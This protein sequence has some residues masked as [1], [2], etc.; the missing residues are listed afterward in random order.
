MPEVLCC[1]LLHSCEC[2]R[3]FAAALLCSAAACG[4]LLLHCCAL[5]LPVLHC[6]ALLLICPITLNPLSLALVLRGIGYVALY[7]AI[8]HC[9]GD[10]LDL[11][12]PPGADD[13]TPV[14][15]W[16]F[17]GVR[18]TPKTIDFT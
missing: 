4:A 7:Y 10:S 8:G 3:C 16:I 17:G 9:A 12:V 13:S 6:C 2:L 1:C 18:T 15:F 14:M 5:L 11:W